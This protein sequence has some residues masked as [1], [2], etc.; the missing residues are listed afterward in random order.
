M[1]SR[2]E[3]EDFLFH[4]AQLLDERRF[5][6]WLELFAPSGIYWL[7]ID[8]TA[9]PD[10]AT[11]LIYDEPLRRRERVFR[12]LHTPAQGQTPPSRTC[13]SITNVRLLAHDDE[14]RV[15]STQVIY[16]MRPGSLIS[17]TRDDAQRVLAGH[18]EH[19]LQFSG[20][21]PLIALKRLL[22]LNRDMPIGNL[23]FLL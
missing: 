8:D 1:L 17:S 2:T 12:L 18:C 22:L 13:H 5:D 3:I 19:R 7:P 23:T 21:K 10:S 14:I 6:E 16:E 15:F 20:N 11:S 9:T 4:E